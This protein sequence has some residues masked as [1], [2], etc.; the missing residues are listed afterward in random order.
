MRV[1]MGRW[2]VRV[3]LRP[4]LAVGIAFRPYMVVLLVGPLFVEVCR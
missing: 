1:R 2:S 3:V 4:M